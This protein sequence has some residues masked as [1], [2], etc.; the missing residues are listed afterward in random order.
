MKKMRSSNFADVERNKIVFFGAENVFLK[1]NTDPRGNLR[2]IFEFLCP[3]IQ[4][5]D[6]TVFV[7]IAVARYIPVCRNHLGS[8]LF[9]P[10]GIFRS[11]GIT[12][13]QSYSYL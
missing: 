5:V 3:S 8:E 7:Y 12:L 1:F 13:D 4:S 6:I 11:V 2:F 9:L 10:V